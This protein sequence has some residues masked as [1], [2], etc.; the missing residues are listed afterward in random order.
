MVFTSTSNHR[1]ETRITSEIIMLMLI[2]HA[3]SQNEKLSHTCKGLLI[4]NHCTVKEIFP[5]D[6][7]W[8]VTSTKL[9]WGIPV[10]L[11]KE[12]AFNVF[13]ACTCPVKTVT[14]GNRRS[15]LFLKLDFSLMGCAIHFHIWKPSI[16]K[17]IKL[18]LFSYYLGK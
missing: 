18:L 11:Q 4:Q 12:S 10:L 1:E 6:I 3:T 14:S 8:H 9:Q 17:M 15:L 7:S 13:G 5:Q 2:L 16:N